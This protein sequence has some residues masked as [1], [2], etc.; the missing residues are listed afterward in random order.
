MNN[1][2]WMQW[3]E[4]RVYFWI[5]T[6]WMILSSC[7]AVFYELTHDLHAAIGSFSVQTRIY[8][9]F[10]AIALAIHTSQGERKTGTLDFSRSLPI[11]IRLIASF[12]IA[13][14]IA[15]LIVPILLSTAVVG[16]ALISGLIEQG[17]PGTFALPTPPL[18]ERPIANIGVSLFQLGAVAAI[19]I[20]S[21]A[22]L[23]L[24]LSVVGCW[25]R[26][27]SQ[28]GFAGILLV[29]FFDLVSGAIKN[30]VSSPFLLTV[31]GG[32]TP[33]SLI[34]NS[35]YG[36]KFGSYSDHIITEGFELSLC[37]ALP[38]LIGLAL[39]FV[40]QFGRMKTAKSNRSLI[41]FGLESLRFLPRFS[42][43]LKSKT[44]AMIWLETRQAIPI[45]LVGLFL[46]F[47]STAIGIVSRNNYTDGFGTAFRSELPHSV[48]LIGILWSVI[49]GASL[50]STDMYSKLG[51]FRRSR[52]IS[53]SHWFW[54]K[55]IIGLFALLSVLTVIPAIISNGIG[56][57]YLAC[58][59]ILDAFMFALSV[60]LTCLTRSPVLGGVLSVMLLLVLTTALSSFDF[61]FN[62]HPLSIHNSMEGISYFPPL[63]Y[64]ITYGILV[65]LTFTLLKLA[66]RL[67]V[68][69]ESP[70]ASVLF[71]YRD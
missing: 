14:A 43:Q 58:F 44:T 38:V 39:A 9:Y 5:F 69:A 65:L 64:L 28:V 36:T 18:P 63:N 66:S 23:L 29:L 42:F 13:S 67:S 57:A 27:Q 1:L 12:K 34:V 22:Q 2:I 8:T 32:I 40:I 20:V 15:V 71:S 45:A 31:L 21:G 4:L 7:Y 61:T 10:A 30:G 62:L 6:I 37:I 47:L 49:L 70:F 35:G 56:F 46:A 19:L 3:K 51:A 26:S 17:T 52:P 16:F 50:F 59:P 41:R 11:G 60:Q 55:T 33:L 48:W 24:I 53:H 68:P 54:N 25:L